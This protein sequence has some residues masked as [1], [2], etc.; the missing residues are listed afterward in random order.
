MV[1]DSVITLAITSDGVETL[2]RDPAETKSMFRYDRVLLLYQL[3]L[4]YILCDLKRRFC[5]S[6]TPFCCFSRFENLL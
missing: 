5:V 3:F 1:C 2:F 6:C 4:C